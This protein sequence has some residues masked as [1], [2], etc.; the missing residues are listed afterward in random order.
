MKRHSYNQICVILF[1]DIASPNPLIN[2][3][4]AKVSAITPATAT[5]ENVLALAT[6]GR[7]TQIGTFLL[8][9]ARKER[10]IANKHH[11]RK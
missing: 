8:A 3:P 11:Q 5:R 4:L 10:D 6:L 2:K 7:A 9:K 1:E